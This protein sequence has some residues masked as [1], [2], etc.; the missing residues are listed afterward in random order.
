MKIGNNGTDFPFKWGLFAILILAGFVA[1]AQKVKISGTVVDGESYERMPLISVYLNN[2]E[3]GVNSNLDGEFTIFAPAGT[4]SLIAK[5]PGYRPYLDTITV[6]TAGLIGLILE[7]KPISAQLDEVLITSKYVNPAIRIVKNAVKNK[8]HNRMDKIDAFEYE[9]YNKLVLTMDKLTDKYLNNF[10]LKGAKNVISGVYFDSTHTDTSKFDLAVFFSES[11]SRF[12]YKKPGHKKEEILAVRATGMKEGNAYNLLN[13]MVLQIDIY[14]N[15]VKLQERQFL[16]PVAESALLDYDFQI[17]NAEID[18]RDTIFGLSILP[19]RPYSLLFKGTMYIDNKDWAINRI[20]LS[21]NSDPN[22]NFIEDFRIRQEYKKQEG[23]WVPT[24]LDL[25]VDFQNG[26]TKRKGGDGVG[27]IGRT[28]AYLYDYKLNQPKPQEFFDQEVLEI[29][30]GADSQT[31]DFWEQARRSPLDQSEALGMKWIDSLQTTGLLDRYVNWIFLIA[32][33]TKEFKYFEVGPYYYLLGNNR[34]EGWRVRCGI[35]T[36]P[37]FSKR[38]YLGGHLAYG[39]RDQRFK[40][41][42]E[43]KYR[44]RI[45]P[46]LEIVARKT[47]EVEQVGFVDFLDE[48][49]SLFETAFRRVPLTQLNYYDENLLELNADVSRG[50]S[51]GLHLKTRAFEPT[52]TFPFLYEDDNGNYQKKYSIA[53]VG[54]DIRVSFKEDYI[55]SSGNRIYLGSKYPIFY[56]GYAYGFKGLLGSQFDYHKVW[57]KMKN[58]WTLG[59][60]GILKY[61]IEAG[62]IFGQLPYPSLNVFSGNQTW[63]LR[64]VG[65]NML[66]YYEFTADRYATVLLEHHL[67]GLVWNKLPLLRKL[68]L[69]EILTFR[70]AWG[71][72]TDA[73]R[74]INN[75]PAQSAI[76]FPGQFI[77]APDR[78]PYMEV[79]VGLANIFKIFRIDGFWR[80]NYHDGLQD[81]TTHRNWGK[82]NNFSIRAH[83]MIRI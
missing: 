31:E 1:N 80:L 44:L 14:D 26:I 54:A 61:N 40:Y 42:A 43:A 60:L 34:A 5:T 62:Q 28:S 48:G 38:L 63:V 79:G 52:S 21:M 41:L 24:V 65:F 19:K 39:F 83:M 51:G 11:V 55:V 7:M 15:H 35:Y 64:Q 22:I 78:E 32:Y 58:K 69:K 6:D 9:S 20:D 74:Q 82:M 68:G 17:I 76:G 13:S 57:I 49:T 47:Y 73:N 56:A 23:F 10:V 77:K 16:S 81:R 70:A 71:T 45:K 46:K 25:E 53:E 8:K 2:T 29:K 72:L 66:N 50:L 67:Q 75:I 27:L 59:R 33:G 3:F 30:S 36:L 12:Y 18:G 4:Y 37:S